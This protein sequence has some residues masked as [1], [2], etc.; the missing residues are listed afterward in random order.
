MFP[1][2][3]HKLSS[4]ADIE[5]G[6]RQAGYAPKSVGA[7]HTPAFL[8]FIFRAGMVI[9]LLFLIALLFVPWQQVAIGNGTVISYTAGN[10][11]QNIQAPILGRINN[12]L[13]QEGQVVAKGDNLVEL[14]DFD[15]QILIRLGQQLDAAKLRLKAAEQAVLA[16]KKNLERQQQ[17]LSKGISS[18]RDYEL[19][20]VELS[21]YEAELSMSQSTLAELEVKISRQSSQLVKAPFD[22]V[23]VRIL[24]PDGGT[25]V[26]AGQSLAILVPQTA[27]RAVELTIKGIDMPL[28]SK[29]RKV[30]LQFE[31]WPAVQFSGWPSVA[32]GTFGGVVEIVDAIDDGNGNYRVLIFPDEGD[33]PW[34]DERYLRQGVKAIGWILLDEVRLGWE[35]WRQLN[36][37]PMT[38]EQPVIGD[39]S[40]SGSVVPG[41]GSDL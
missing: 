22:G 35:L 39:Q 34:P 38:V 25:V 28:I 14:A 32:I 5:A 29:G 41:R 17:L 26:N 16:G 6:F 2:E 9:L 37:F 1:I 8:V 36:S 31:G 19:A 3:N 33:Q 27:D 40:N 23:V 4:Y 30:R 11:G 15:E 10:R 12:W 24:A 18:Q 7:S 20:Q 13:V 21:R